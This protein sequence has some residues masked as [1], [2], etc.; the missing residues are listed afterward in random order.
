MIKTYWK[1]PWSDAIPVPI[2]EL[3][4]C[5]HGL[6]QSCGDGQGGSFLLT[7][8]RILEHWQQYGDKLDAYIL[9]SVIGWYSIGVRYSD[10]GPQYLS[11]L[12]NQEA[13]KDLLKIYT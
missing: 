10:D 1:N 8:E 12:A 3:V 9:P 4:K 2:K 5:V 6:N 7:Q 11:P 13:T